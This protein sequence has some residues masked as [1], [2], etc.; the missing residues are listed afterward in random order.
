M[1]EQVKTIS[2]HAEPT[3]CPGGK[4]FNWTPVEDE[5]SSQCTPET[6]PK[7]SIIPEDCIHRAAAALINK[8]MNRAEEAGPRPV[9]VFH[10]TTVSPC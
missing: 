1:S 8:H 5:L 7:S 10:A 3:A 6:A 9:T 2:L 4:L